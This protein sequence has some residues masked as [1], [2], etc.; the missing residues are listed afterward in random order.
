[1]PREE[2][3]SSRG[4]AEDLQSNNDDEAEC[5]LNCSTRTCDSRKKIEDGR[6]SL[7]HMSAL[8]YFIPT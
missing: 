8:R 2:D 4:P 5:Q 1:M 6:P 3:S 7:F